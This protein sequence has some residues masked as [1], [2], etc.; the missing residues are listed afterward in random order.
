MGGPSAAPTQE[1]KVVLT[2]EQEELKKLAMPGIR[3]FAAATPERYQDPTV[4]GF[5]PSQ[6]AGQEKALAAAGTQSG[7][8]TS[9]VNASNYWLSPGA[10]DVNNDPSVRSA[11]DASVRPITQNLTEQVLPSIRSGSIANGGYGGSRSGI[12]EGLAAGRASQAVGDTAAKVAEGAREANVKAQLQALQL[13]PQTEQSTLA[14]ATTTSGV[15]DVRQ[16]QA[17][18]ELD[19]RVNNFNFDQYAPF[20]KSKEIMALLNGIP[21]AS[22][23]TTGSTPSGPSTLQKSLA[24]AGTGAA[25]GSVF[26]PWGTLAGGAAG[27][28]M[29]FF[30]K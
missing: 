3:E 5:D 10:I 11:I 13:L 6:T 25:M 9:G 2:P 18:R 15:G 20:L 21:G 23:L 17:Q 4:A 12:A 26:G 1:S 24:G 8:S 22:T 27:G 16:Q 29:P 14:D 28:V 30:F 19:A 7:L